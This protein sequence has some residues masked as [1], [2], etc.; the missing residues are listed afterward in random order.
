M[1]NP[2]RPELALGN[3]INPGLGQSYEPVPGFTALKQIAYFEVDPTDPKTVHPLRL[4][5]TGNY[6]IIRP[7]DRLLLS[8]SRVFYGTGLRVPKNVSFAGVASLILKTDMPASVFV[9][10]FPHAPRDLYSAV[11]GQRVQA[12]NATT[13]P[14]SPALLPFWQVDSIADVKIT[15]SPFATSGL[16]LF[17]SE[18]DAT[19]VVESNVPLQVTGKRDKILRVV[20]EVYTMGLAIPTEKMDLWGYN[21]TV[22]EI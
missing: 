12:M 3:I 22:V 8:G 10:A 17:P 20:V 1:P 16:L 19:M 7:D 9:T 4:P 15:E 14:A 11:L 13:A 21:N 5:Y 2:S 18:K 6:E